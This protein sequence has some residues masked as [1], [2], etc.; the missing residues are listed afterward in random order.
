MTQRLRE[1]LELQIA[2]NFVGR[3]QEIAH[4]HHLL[5][6]QST[7]LVFVHGIGG[8][9]KS[10]LLEVFAA[11]AQTLGAVVIK[12]DCR[13]IKPSVAGFHQEL[14]TAVGGEATDVEEMALRLSGLGERVILALD[15]Y[16]VFRMMDTWL[17]QVFIPSLPDNTRVRLVYHARLGWVGT[18][19]PAW[20]VEQL[21]GPSA[22]IA[23]WRF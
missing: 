21:G 10:S 14:A 16:E 8:I 12:L 2:R 5:I 20:A 13:A 7:P 1:L 6:E 19:Y 3:A 23:M 11:Q 18:E 9:G 4:L 22:I 17:R 15:T